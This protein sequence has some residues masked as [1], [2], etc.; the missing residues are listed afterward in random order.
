L[1]GLD[2]PGIIGFRIRLGRPPEPPKE[3]KKTNSKKTWQNLYSGAEHHSRGFPPAILQEPLQ[4][5]R[6]RQPVALKPGSPSPHSRPPESGVLFSWLNAVRGSC[7]AKHRSVGSPRPRVQKLPRCL[8][9][10]TV[11]DVSYHA[12]M[13]HLDYF[14]ALRIH[15][16]F[17]AGL[18][19]GQIAVLIHRLAILVD[20]K[21]RH[22]GTIACFRWKLTTAYRKSR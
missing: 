9:A 1:S 6:R 12:A 3:A 21:S 17:R 10:F 7:R 8:S 16:P 2:K 22:G 15:G 20:L 13:L 14:F 19:L 18:V 4:R 11:G 5:S